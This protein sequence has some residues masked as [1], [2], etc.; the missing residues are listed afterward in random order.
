MKLNG[1]TYI[2]LDDAI[3]CLDDLAKEYELRHKGAKLKLNT[4]Y[5]SSTFPWNQDKIVQMKEKII[6]RQAQSLACMSA[7]A[8]IM[9]LG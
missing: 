3:E 6:S 2:K 9:E 1:N 5:T 4:Y 8:S 7:K